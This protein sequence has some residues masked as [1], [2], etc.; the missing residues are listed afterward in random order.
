[1]MG[2]K[3]DGT[4]NVFYYNE[5]VVNNTTMPESTLKK[6]HNVIAYHQTRESQAAGI[7]RIAKEGGETNLADLFTKLLDGPRS[8]ELAGRILW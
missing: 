4:T 8:R 3:V 7:V 6:K 5:S 2:I 1:M